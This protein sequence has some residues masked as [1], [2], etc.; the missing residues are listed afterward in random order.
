ML[1][2]C[3]SGNGFPQALPDTRRR[4]FSEISRYLFRR[5][6]LEGFPN[7]NVFTLTVF[8]NTIV[9]KSK[10]ESPYGTYNKR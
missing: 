8:V 1:Q 3:C 7:R 5:F 2:I 4:G 9:I 6:I 10:G